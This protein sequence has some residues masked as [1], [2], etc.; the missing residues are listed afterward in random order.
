MFLRRFSDDNHTISQILDIKFLNS[1]VFQLN[2]IRLINLSD[3]DMSISNISIQSY[4]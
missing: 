4:T 1:G 3:A 2:T